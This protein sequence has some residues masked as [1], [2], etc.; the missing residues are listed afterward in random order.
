[1]HTLYSK[2]VGGIINI[3]FEEENRKRNGNG[4]MVIENVDFAEN[5]V[6]L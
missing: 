5:L 1:M 6:K 3:I 4:Y 2:K